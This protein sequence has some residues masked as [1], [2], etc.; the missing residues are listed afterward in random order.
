[1]A[2]QW[3]RVAEN[4][5]RHKES[6]GL[7]LR[8]KVGGKIIRKA[9]GVKEV[10]IGK[11]KRDTLLAELRARAGTMSKG[12]A[13]TVAEALAMTSAWYESRP[14][15]EQKASSLHYRLQIIEVLGR[16]LPKTSPSIWTR[17]DL[18]TWWASKGVTRYSSPRKNGML[19]TVRKMFDLMIERGLRGDD[20][21]ARLKRVRVITEEPSVPSHEDFKRVL[22][23]I[24][25]QNSD[26]A[27]ESRNFVAFLAYSGLRIGEARSVG[28]QDVGEIEI[29]V[30]G[31]DLGTKNREA[32]RV[33]IIEPMREL[34]NSMRSEDSTGP[35]FS[36]KSPR[37]AIS[38]ACRRLK[39]AHF[40]PHTFR[41][42]FSTACIELGVDIPTVA[43]WLGHKDGGSLLMKTYSHLRDEHSQEQAAKVK[44]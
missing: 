4:L 31:G 37:F 38:G 14:E 1:M 2:K 9:L 6:G 3:E 26:H 29:V 16:T 33:P 44:F 32:R 19:D 35:L 42:L 22:E 27:T 12:K 15:D 20:P 10:R 17:P 8:A 25:A 43:K 40:T 34:L 28:W 18:E 41:H 13:L 11:L 5:V 39:L 7:Y 23:D 30:S 36:I 24:A 21:S